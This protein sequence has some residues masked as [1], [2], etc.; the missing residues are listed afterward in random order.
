MDYPPI[1]GRIGRKKYPKLRDPSHNRAFA[2]YE[3]TGMF[4]DAGLTVA[5]TEQIIKRH[6]FVTWTGRQ[7]CTP[8]TIKRL[9]VLLHQAPPAAAWLQAECIGT[10]EASFANHH[11]IILGIRD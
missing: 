11:L 3:W 7:G 2:E 10:P 5:H 8:E 9:I 1:I 4:L 6:D